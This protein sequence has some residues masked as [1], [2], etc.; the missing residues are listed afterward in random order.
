MEKAVNLKKEN[1]K[2]QNSKKR[3]LDILYMQFIR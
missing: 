2:R 3:K 1:L